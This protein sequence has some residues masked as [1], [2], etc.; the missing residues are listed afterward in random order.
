M[1]HIQSSFLS[2]PS[3]QIIVC[4]K[5]PERP[6]LIIF[7]FCNCAV[8]TS[9]FFCHAFP[10]GC[11]FLPTPLFLAPCF[12]S[13]HCPSPPLFAAK[14]FLV[15]PFPSGV[16]SFST[17]QSHFKFP[18]TA[19]SNSQNLIAFPNKSMIN[20]IVHQFTLSRPSSTSGS[21]SVSWLPSL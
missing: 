4:K 16:L 19:W 11:L 18:V 5:I 8:S 9:L 14:A 7:F 15:K 10:P 2:Q 13:T 1:V 12:S 21:S 6:L 3:L 17:I 20:I